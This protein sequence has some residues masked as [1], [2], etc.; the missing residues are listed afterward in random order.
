MSIRPGPRNLI[1]D[2]DGILV[3]NAEDHRRRSG[4]TVVYPAARCPAAADV[5]GGAP[6]TLNIQALDATSLRNEVDAVVLSGG[7]MYGLDAA[8]GVVAALGARG[9]G[10]SFGGMVV[11]VVP[12]AIL[13]DLASGGEKDWGE[14]PPY[15]ALGRAAL[16]AIG[17]DFALG[18]AGAGLGARSGAL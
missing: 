16:E 2:V 5:R 7:S 13:F 4:V 9:R 18:N 11:P 14:A 15:A 10:M 3:G 17:P 8:G 1:T 6:G 12:G